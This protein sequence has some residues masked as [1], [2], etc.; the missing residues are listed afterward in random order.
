MRVSTLNFIN[1]LRT[2]GVRISLSESMDAVQAVAATGVGRDVLREALPAC[3]VKEEE[4]RFAFDEVFARFFAGPAKKNK[5]KPLPHSG[6]RV[7]RRTTKTTQR[8]SARLC[9]R[10]Q[11]ES[12]KKPFSPQSFRPLEPESLKQKAQSL[13]PAS[14]RSRGESRGRRTDAG[15]SSTRQ[16]K[17]AFTQITQPIR[18]AQCSGSKRVG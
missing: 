2:V 14:Q 17:G 8:D 5:K 15:K 1:E 16:T 6:K 10:P 13:Q 18:L 12:E 11:K 9:E 3:V 7:G 4:D